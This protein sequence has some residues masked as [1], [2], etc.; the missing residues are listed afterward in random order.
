LGSW[1]VG[2]FRALDVG[3]NSYVHFVTALVF[4]DK[5]NIVIALD[6]K[7]PLKVVVGDNKWVESSSTRYEAVVSDGK[8]YW[9]RYIKPK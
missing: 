4:N 7:V 1:G 2:Y 9:S 3:G 6:G 8:N 5:T